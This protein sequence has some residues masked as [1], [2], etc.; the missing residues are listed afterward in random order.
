MENESPVAALAPEKAQAARFKGPIWTLIVVSPVIAEVLSGSTRLSFLFALIPEILVWG[1]GALLCREMVRR[2]RAGGTSLLL[3]GLGLSIAEEFVIQQ[4]SLA[5]LPFPGAN[6][7]YGR[8]GGVNWLYFLFMLGYESVWVVL[9]PVAVTELIFPARRRQPWL[10]KGGIIGVCV[11]FAVGCYIAWFTWTQ[12]ALPAKMHV[13]PYHPPVTTIAA[14]VA[15]I[16]LLICAAYGLRS[17]GLTGSDDSRAAVNPWVPGIAA[18]VLGVG[19]YQ[20]IGLV[21]TPIHHPVWMPIT[22]GCAGALLTFAL[23]LRLS[24]GRPWGDRPRWAAA[25]GAIMACMS[26]GYVS[27]AGWSRTDLEAKAILNVLAF[28]GLLLLARKVWQ[29]K[30]EDQA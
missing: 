26:V 6:A 29:R 17:F 12:R 13:P 9:V 1:C 28:A 8:M 27:T 21:F 14:G 11:A 10:R 3:L 19:W 25:F 30:T 2:W 18:F 16:L 22:A 23:F 15:A 4:T 20:L 5:P 24:A 7:G